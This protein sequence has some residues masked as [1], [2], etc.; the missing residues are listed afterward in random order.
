MSAKPS[1]V[2]EPA[3]PPFFFA[4]ETI[5]VPATIAA[6]CAYSRAVYDA[7]PS[8]SEP[9]ITGTIL[10]DLASVATGNETPAASAAFVQYLAQ[11][12]VAPVSAKSF[13]GSPRV[14]AVSS[15]PTAPIATFA[16]ASSTCRNHTCVNA[17]P[18]A[19][20]YRNTSSCSS[21]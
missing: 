20:A 1:A 19:A 4:S 18:S 11:T 15:S 16:S 10:P 7:P 8:R 21:P 12:C 2:P 3:P 9:S 14:P 13:C 5:A 6:T 17:P